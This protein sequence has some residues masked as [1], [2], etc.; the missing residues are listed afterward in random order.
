MKENE[1][2]EKNEKLGKWFILGGG[3]IAIVILI[4]I[5]IVV[6]WA[7]G[8][9]KAKNNAE[10]DKQLPAEARAAEHKKIPLEEEFPKVVT[11]GTEWKRI[12]LPYCSWFDISP[13]TGNISVVKIRLLDGKEFSLL[14]GGSLFYAGEKVDDFGKIPGVDIDVRSEMPTKIVVSAEK[15]T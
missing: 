2:N 11:V 8:E 14:P 7:E 9:N 5:A 1:K 15:K 3:G 4:V 12:K 6:F 13:E 10:I